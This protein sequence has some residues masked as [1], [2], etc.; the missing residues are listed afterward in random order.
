[1]SEIR[2]TAAIY[3]DAEPVLPEA[4]SRRERELA[5]EIERLEDELKGRDTRIRDVVGQV[6]NPGVTEAHDDL[7]HY[8]IDNKKLLDKDE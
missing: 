6:K 3:K 4:A 5:L 1:M 8:I 7:F 2:G